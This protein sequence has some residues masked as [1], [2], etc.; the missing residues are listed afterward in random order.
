MVKQ[1]HEH[2]RCRQMVDVTVDH[3]RNATSGFLNMKGW[4][5][6]DL[7]SMSLQNLEQPPLERFV[8]TSIVSY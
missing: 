8:D 7:E 5:L 1:R 4:E 2:L 6:G 3:R